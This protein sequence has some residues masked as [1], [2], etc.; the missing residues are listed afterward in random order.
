MNPLATIFYRIHCEAITTAARAVWENQEIA[1][2]IASNA[3]HILDLSS[4]TNLRFFSGKPTKCILGGLFYILG[5]RFNA[6]KTQKEIADFLCTTEFSVSSSY[7]NWLKEFPQFFTD[8][9][10]FELPIFYQSRISV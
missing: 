2:D 3:L 10:A 5:F 8:I 4:W 7:K 6:V 1:D 9:S